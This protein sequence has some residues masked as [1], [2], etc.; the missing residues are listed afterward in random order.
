MCSYGP[1]GGYHFFAGRDAARA[2]VTGCFEEDLTPDLRGVE[3]MYIP[4]DN[5]MPVEEEAREK[6]VPKAEL[7]VRRQQDA[8][9]A[10]KRVKAVIEGWSKVFAGETGKEYLEVGKVK[11]EEGWLE[12]MPKR[13][14]CEKASME[15]P[16]MR[17]PKKQKQKQQQQ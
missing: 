11:R 2:F 7:K 12:K 6:E 8:R 16:K 3:M 9:E 15:R 17:K 13:Q 4:V 1:G 14:L 5:D 10:R